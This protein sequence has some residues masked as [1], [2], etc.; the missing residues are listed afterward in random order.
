MPVFVQLHILHE[1]VGICL[2]PVMRAIG[3]AYTADQSAIYVSRV[4]FEATWG[5]PGVCVNEQIWVGIHSLVCELELTAVGSG[6]ICSQSR[7]VC[8]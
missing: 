3:A 2:S 5:G 6:L 1:V 8:W 7:V 4:R